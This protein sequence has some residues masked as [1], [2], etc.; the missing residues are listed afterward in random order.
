LKEFS[1]IQL[2]ESLFED[3]IKK[4][5]E[6]FDLIHVD[7]LHHY[8]PTYDCGEW[9]LQHSD[10]VIFHDTISHP[11]VKQACEDLANK[12]N[13]EFYNYPKSFGLGILIKKI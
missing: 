10:C 1:N 5:T 9:A 2:V 13:F 3:Y 7:I 6:R 4:V 12:Y 8:K 11:T